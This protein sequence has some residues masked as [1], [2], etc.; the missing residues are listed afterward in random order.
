MT[1]R[2]GVL[3]ILSL[4]DFFLR[5][6]EFQPM[7]RYSWYSSGLGELEK[8]DFKTAKEICFDL[9]D[10]KCSTCEKD[11]FI[12]CNWCLKFLCFEECFHDYHVMICGKR[13]DFF[14]SLTHLEHN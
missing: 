5:A 10:M 14:L 7:I 2:N 8:P 13:D 11:A 1:T 3:R 6:P 12:R 4:V 9:G